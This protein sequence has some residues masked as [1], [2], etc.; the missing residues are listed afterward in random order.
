MISSRSQER[1]RVG[2]PHVEKYISPSLPHVAKPR[3]QTLADR[4]ALF[5][6]CAGD[7]PSNIKRKEDSL[8][9][10]LRKPDVEEIVIEVVNRSDLSIKST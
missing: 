9:K 3:M 10:V 7:E 1:D 5:A 4:R 6:P 2:S 8:L